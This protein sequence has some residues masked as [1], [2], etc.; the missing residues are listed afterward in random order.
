M[1]LMNDIKE[2]PAYSYSPS[3]KVLKQT[4]ELLNIRYTK[5][6]TGK[7]KPKATLQ[8]KKKSHPNIQFVNL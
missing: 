6:K 5:N 8:E 4:W 7:K 2:N 1:Y 3:F